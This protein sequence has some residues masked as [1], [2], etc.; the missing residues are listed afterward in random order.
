MRQKM[1]DTA[2]ECK[3]ALQEIKK[4]VTPPASLLALMAAVNRF[5]LDRRDVGWSDT[6]SPDFMKNFYKG[7]P[8][9][10]KLSLN[11]RLTLHEYHQ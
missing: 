3:K 7:I 10:G 9:S 1:I 5:V 8:A 6:T 2:Y 4:L 11:Q